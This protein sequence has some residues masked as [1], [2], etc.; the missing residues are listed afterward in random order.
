MDALSEFAILTAPAVQ[1]T[2]HRDRD[3][4]HKAICRNVIR[5]LRPRFELP[6]RERQLPG[7]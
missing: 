5:G 3:E 6:G 2:Q 7:V 1:S 4:R